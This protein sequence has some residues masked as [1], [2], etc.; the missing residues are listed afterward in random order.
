[1]SNND[2]LNVI[3][4]INTIVKNIEARGINTPK[5]KEEYFW[6]NH[7]DIM[8]NYPFLV[9]QICS[10]SDMTMLNMMLEQLKKIK[11]GTLNQDDADKLV[12]EKLASDYL[13]K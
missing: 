5:Q 6:K 7:G 4:N 9:H 2:V 12:G 10:N 13:P 3:N 1:M 11:S 8:N